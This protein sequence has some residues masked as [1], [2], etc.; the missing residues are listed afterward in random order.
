MRFNKETKQNSITIHGATV[1][2]PTG[3]PKEGSKAEFALEATYLLVQE[4]QRA[5]QARKVAV[6]LMNKLDIPDNSS[7]V[8][9]L[10]G[11]VA[12]SNLKEITDWIL[13][14]TANS[15]DGSELENPQFIRDLSSH[16]LKILM[17]V[18]NDYYC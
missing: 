1:T 16:L 6:V 2:T 3:G 5:K 7:I 13:R 11:G 14:V 9:L 15:I 17:E 10:C 8:G 4:Q 12:N 18:Q